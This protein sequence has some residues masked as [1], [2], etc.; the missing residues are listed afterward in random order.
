MMEPVTTLDPRYS[1]PA[2]APT[3]WAETRAALEAAE[4]AWLVTLRPDGS[5]HA[6]P[7]VPVWAEDGFH[8]TTRGVEQKGRNLRADNR[9]LLQV[10]R[11]DWQD[12]LDIV[13]EGRATLTTD[14]LVLGQLAA[15]WRERWDGRWAFEASGDRLDHPGRF[16]VLT[17]SVHP[18]RVL[19]FAEG[20]FGHTLH[21]FP[22]DEA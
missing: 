11:L 4:L 18:R 15:V 12:G 17:Y 16:A 6:T 3:P 21:R 1:D 5:P 8:F 10:G 9:V 13:V 20:R 7:V 22:G 14:P 2:A 19:A